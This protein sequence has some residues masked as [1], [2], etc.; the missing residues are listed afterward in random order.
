MRTNIR[1]I[2]SVI[3]FLM[4]FHSCTN[5]PSDI[6]SHKEMTRF[7][8][9][10]HKLDGALAAKGL[11]STDNR[12]NVYYYNALLQ[13]EGITKAEFDS[14]L[15]WYAKN[16]KYFERVYVDVV[17]KLSKLDEQVKSGYF[18]P[19][20]SALLRNINENV[21]PLART[22]FKL[23]KDSTP[24]QIKFAIRTG[25]L[26]WGDQYKLSF[27]H[28][29]GKSNISKNQNAVIRIHYANNISD[30]IVCKTH[31]DSLLRR[32]TITLKANRQL[33][34]DSVSGALLNFKAVKGKF[35]VLIDSVKLIRKYDSLAQDSIQK[36]VYKLEHPEVIDQAYKPTLRVR[37]KVLLQRKNDK[38]E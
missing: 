20:D 30:S 14:S 6:L 22:N 35:N 32:Y 11:G 1:T 38:P 5:R 10:L 18:H 29:A 26:A 13:K 19:V 17:E 2:F 23:T 8:V 16:P 28:R 15:V 33:R 21:W 37:S 9:E 3:L 7:L 34:V 25:R 4:I 24:T 36:V 12:E 31:N 27:L